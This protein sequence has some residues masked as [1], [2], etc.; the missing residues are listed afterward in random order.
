[1]SAEG[2][3]KCGPSSAK[4]AGLQSS[5]SSSES[6]RSGSAHA[7]GRGLSRASSATAGGLLRLLQLARRR[8]RGSMSARLHLSTRPRARVSCDGFQTLRY[9]AV[10]SSLRDHLSLV[11]AFGLGRLAF[12]LL[13]LEC[14]MVLGRSFG[15]AALDPCF[16]YRMKGAWAMSSTGIIRIQTHLRCRE[17]PLAISIIDVCFGVGCGRHPQR[18]GRLLARGHILIGDT[19]GCACSCRDAIETGWGAVPLDS[20][21]LVV[22]VSRLL[23]AIGRR[24]AFDVLRRAGGKRYPA[25]AAGALEW[26][27][28]C[29][30]GAW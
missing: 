26:F 22:A 1:V 15:G 10:S 5:E 28:A 2:R 9:S 14:R 18:S 3:G 8:W 27:R 24:T 12:R 16:G 6:V 13:F 30:A 4:L 7:G 19:R 23:L 20:A 17:W 21:F 25:S 29:G 11:D